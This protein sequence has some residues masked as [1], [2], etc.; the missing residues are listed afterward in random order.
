MSDSV[1][2]QSLEAGSGESFLRT[3]QVR[4]FEGERA[5]LANPPA[6][7]L[8]QA[9]GRRAWRGGHAEMEMERQ[10]GI[11]ARATCD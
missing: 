2:R 9:R 4:S 6:L 11:T 7:E 5:V 1:R 3:Q 10:E 8:W